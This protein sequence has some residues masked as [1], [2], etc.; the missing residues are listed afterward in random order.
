LKEN[1]VRK[2]FLVVAILLM[3]DIALQFYFAAV[4]VF[5]PGSTND[6]QFVLHATNGRIILPLLCLLVIA[7]AALARAGGRTIG[8]SVVPLVLV[9][10]QTVLFILGSLTGTTE[11]EPTFAGSIVLGFH[12]LIG[13]AAFGTASILAQRA[14]RLVTTG[15]ALR[16]DDSVPKRVA[17]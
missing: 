9:L 2:V 1:S 14:R 13:M 8:L 5:G 12:A 3:V 4:G 17:T 6:E 10:F 7:A 11:E 15:S 16:T